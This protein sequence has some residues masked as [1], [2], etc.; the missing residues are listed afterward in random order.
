[1]HLYNC[2]FMVHMQPIH[3]SFLLSL[4]IFQPH[5]YFFYVLQSQCSCSDNITHEYKYLVVKHHLQRW[6]LF[7]IQSQL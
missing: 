7:S 3:A 5:A 2:P 6:E 1:M 4:S